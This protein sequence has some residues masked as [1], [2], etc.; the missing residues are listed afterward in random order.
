GAD[1]EREGTEH[2]IEEIAEIYE[3]EVLAAC[4]GATPVLGGYSLGMLVAFELANR[5]RRRGIEVPLLCS[6]DGF[7]PGFPRLLPL[8]QRI[9]SHARVFFGGDMLA[10]RTYLRD[11]YDRVRGRVLE[12]LGRAHE[13]FEVPD[14][15]TDPVARRHW[16]KVAAGLWH[17]RC[18]YQPT[19]TSKSNLLLI[20]TAT[21][22]VWLGN[23]FEDPLY[24]WSSFVTGRIGVAVVPGEHLHM[25]ENP[26]ALAEILAPAIAQLRAGS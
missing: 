10:K 24:G 11:R 14:A 16:Q 23:S 22:N 8:A 26:R 2:S 7:A 13:A 1:D 18:R 5:F 15:V 20:R 3:P 12:R 4:R 19:D 25:F 21:P 17:A 6:F 9:E